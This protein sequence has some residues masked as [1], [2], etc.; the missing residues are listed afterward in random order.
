MQMRAIRQ[1]QLK[2]FNRA[3]FVTCEPERVC[4]D[5]AMTKVVV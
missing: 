1:A 2:G 4:D 5:P 3:H